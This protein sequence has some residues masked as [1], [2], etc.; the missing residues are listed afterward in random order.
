[1][2]IELYGAEKMSVSGSALHSMIQ[3][4]N[5]PIL[6]L[7]VRESIQNSLD[8]KD[9]TSK[10]KFVTVE[11]N[12]GTFRRDVLE[13][14]LENVT[15]SSRPEWGDSFISISDRNTVGLTGN[16]KDKSSNLYKLVFGIMDGQKNAGA[17][18]SWGIGKTVYFRVGV[19]FVLYYSRI[20][21]REGYE[22]LIAAALVED[23][24]Q[25][26][27]LLPAID[28]HK[29]GIAWWGDEVFPGAGKVRECR[30]QKTIGRVLESFGLKPYEGETTG[31]I[32][33]I[34]FID[35]NN[36]LSH[37][38]PTKES[39]SNVPSWLCS[40]D[41]YIEISIQKWYSARLNNRKYPYGKY[42]NV[43]INSKP[44]GPP[45]MAPFF[46]L[47]QALYNKAALKNVGSPDADT[48]NFCDCEIHCV[49]IKVNSYIKDNCAGHLAYALVNR[50]HLGM[51]PPDNLPSPY[52]Y[53]SSERDDEDFGNPILFFCRKPGMAV[54]YD[55]NKDG[56]TEWLYRV[57]LTSEDEYLVAYFVLNSESL[58][59]N[60][61]SELPLEEYVRKSELADHFQWDDIDLSGFNAPI[62]R[63]IKI[64][65][66]N[67][68]RSAFEEAVKDVEKTIDAGL[69]NLLGRVLLPPE[70][71]GRRPSPA[72]SSQ[73]SGGGSSVMRKNIRYTFDIT[74]YTANGITI[75]MTAKTGKKAVRT[76]G[77]SL[78]MSS[79]AGTISADSWEKDTGIELP[80]FIN[81]ICFTSKKIDGDSA[82]ET[83]SLMKNETL[84]AGLLR[85]VPLLSQAGEWYGLSVGFADGEGHSIDAEILLDITIRRKDV[86]PSIQFVF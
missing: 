2:K 70:G 44:F 15:L 48:V 64:N 84:S 3:N 73:E 24:T 46:R 35:Q 19:G 79:L 40:I 52:E 33:I 38:L 26:N 57:P 50:S 36:L 80:F 85:Y 7:F 76:L 75:K 41:E 42:L 37:N 34:P 68:L 81:S 55:Y 20:K 4:R 61:G 45:G 62:V 9:D 71:F 17:G 78:E 66:A 13:E 23:E 5:T 86:K 56:K 32:I 12:T 60:I 27:A 58:L 11:F 82:A 31:T 25:R 14:V 83:I 72:V 65:V 39:C 74:S 47:L 43:V 59:Q 49:E 51:N 22:S 53:L 69:G 1:M 77:F 16:Y 21:T 8:A 67:K 28:G 6:D 30:E 54:N 29:Y 18:G 10:S 63:R